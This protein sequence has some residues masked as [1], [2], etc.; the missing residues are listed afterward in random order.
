MAFEPQSS[1]ARTM[2][3]YGGRIPSLNKSNEFTAG[4]ETGRRARNQRLN[5]QSA[6]QAQLTQVVESLGSQ[7]AAISMMPEQQR[8]QAWKDT[9]VAFAGS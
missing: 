3:I 8:D 9:V 6:Q 4:M 1:I 5:E 2:N 7:A